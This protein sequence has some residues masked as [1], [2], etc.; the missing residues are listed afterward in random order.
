MIKFIVTIL[1]WMMLGIL[2]LGLFFQVTPSAQAQGGG[3][4]EPDIP[5]LDL[6]ILVDESASMWRGTDIEGKRVDAFNLLIDSLGKYDRATDDVR[7]SVIAFGSAEVTEVVIPFTVVKFDTVDDIK[8][9]YR[10]YHEQLAQPDEKGEIAGLGWTDVLR[11]LELAEEVLVDPDRGHLRSHK[12]AI[13]ILSDGKPETEQINED[14]NEFENKISQYVENIFSQADRLK[15]EEGGLFYYDGICAPLKKGAVPIYTIAIREGI[16]LHER[17]QNIWLRLADKSGG[18][19]LSAEDPNQPL[20]LFE[21]GSFYYRIGQML[22]CRNDEYEVLEVPQIKE[23]DVSTLYKSIE[24]TILKENPDIDVRIYRPGSNEPV[25]SDEDRINLNKSTLDEVWTIAKSDPWVGPW[26]V[27][28]NGQGKVLFSYVRDTDVFKIEELQPENKFVKACVPIEIA[29]KITDSEGTEIT[30]HV[31][32]F[33]L[34]IER[35]DSK[36]YPIRD[37]QPDEADIFRAVYEDT[38]MDGRYELSGV[39]EISDLTDAGETIRWPWRVAVTSVLDPYLA[40]LSPVDGKTYPSGLP[41]PLEVDVKVG[42]RLDEFTPATNPPVFAKIYKDGAEVTS[43][44]LTYDPDSG[45]ARLNNEIPTGL[46][47]AGEY[48]LEF[49]GGFGK[50]RPVESSSLT[51]FVKMVE[52]AEAVPNTPTPTSIPTSTPPP[53]P[54]P[55]PLSIPSGGTI[56]GILG[57]I[58]LLAL[59]IGAAIAYS[60]MPTLPLIILDGPSGPDHI[61]GGLGGKLAAKKSYTADEETISLKFSPFKNEHGQNI[62]QVTLLN[63]TDKVRLNGLLLYQ[64]SPRELTD[65]ST[66]IIGDDPYYVS[67]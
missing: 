36:L 35:P 60:Q 58:I 12:P 14:V 54:T 48:T 18:D 41:I 23:Y 37:I 4:N 43:Y 19:Y 38:C 22:N 61:K 16:A 47:E 45:S 27:E 42:D 33:N 5:K 7:V 21:L 49:S 6:V 64:N 15:S 53:T 51:F 25:T 46:L 31:S 62:A 26:R 57:C 55:V 30:K 32:S 24:F 10:R 3:E 28:L 8:E 50:N 11:G 65:D 9:E 13:I 67:I 29:L 63:D 1:R 17:Y 66:L 20:E 56:A 52:Q 2:F 44:Q 39:F 59:L 40:V 34:T